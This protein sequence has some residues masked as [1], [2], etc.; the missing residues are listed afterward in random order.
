MGYSPVLVE[1]NAVFEQVGAPSGHRTPRFAKGYKT[2]FRSLLARKVEAVASK[3]VLSLLTPGKKPIVG[4]TADR[5]AFIDNGPV[6][7]LETFA[8]SQNN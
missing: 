1:A 3:I 8:Q 4:V 6:S 7:S 5:F 2:L